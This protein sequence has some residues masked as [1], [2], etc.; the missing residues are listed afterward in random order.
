MAATPSSCHNSSLTPNSLEETF[1]PIPSPAT[2][3]VNLNLTA[4][5][6]PL[7]ATP[8]DPI[9]PS[10]SFFPVISH[11]HPSTQTTVPIIGPST[12]PEDPYLNDSPNS[13]GSFPFKSPSIGVTPLLDIDHP[14]DSINIVQPQDLTSSGISHEQSFLQQQEE[15]RMNNLHKIVHGRNSRRGGPAVA[16]GPPS[17]RLGIVNPSFDIDDEPSSPLLP[18][19]VLTPSSPHH[20][21]QIFTFEGFKKEESEGGSPK[22]SPL[23]SF[24][25]TQSTSIASSPQPSGV[26]CFQ[27]GINQITKGRGSITAGG[28]VFSSFLFSL[29]KSCS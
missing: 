20:D 14:N 8:P 13:E 24:A 22:P 12:H 4:I 6:P 21:L 5:D 11:L 15:V 29:L 26:K 28:G 27:F 17:S 23:S 1:S 10:L 2:G 7:P 19:L 16:G 18:S 3:V 9:L 25:V